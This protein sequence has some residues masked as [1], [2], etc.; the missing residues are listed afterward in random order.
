MSGAFVVGLHIPTPSWLAYSFQICGQ[1]IA[2]GV[3][4]PQLAV[5]PEVLQYWKRLVKVSPLSVE[6]ATAALSGA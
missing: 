5:G 4:V 2:T 3:V 6:V 1:I